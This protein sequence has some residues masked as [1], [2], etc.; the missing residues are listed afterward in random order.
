MSVSVDIIIVN[1][2]SA[3]HLRRCLDSM[4]LASRE[5]LELARVV[6]VDNASSDGSADDLFY[7][8]LPLVFLRNSENRGFAAACNQG[9]KASQADYLLFLN[10]DVELR[11]DSLTTPVRFMEDPA[12]DRVGIC[13]IQLVG[14]ERHVARSCSPF[15]TL[16]GYLLKMLGLEWMSA[17]FFLK[18]E[19]H[20]ESRRVDVVTGAFFLVRRGV[21][22]ELR[23]F[24]EEFFVYFE[25]LDFSYR[26]HQAGWRSQ[27]LASAQAQH[28]GGGCSQQA[29][30]ARLFYSLRS[31]IL[32]GYKH[33]TWVEATGLSFG[34][35]F[36][37]PLSRIVWAG[38]RGSLREMHETLSAY[39]MLWLEI[40][41][42]IKRERTRARREKA[43]V[44]Q[45][46]VQS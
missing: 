22:Q 12:K 38:L 3:L 1:W 18:L 37:E 11:E 28:V 44:R 4:L 15:P 23:G 17:S 5:G 19:D 27:F 36:I 34:T 26:A 39:Q 13:G 20:F 32:Y 42:K 25:E 31:R 41:G 45:D 9:A 46:R 43:P 24:D 8:G 14:P 2:N 30:A 40:L 10:P 29:K 6:V 33:F 16:G 35:L 7:P 21:F